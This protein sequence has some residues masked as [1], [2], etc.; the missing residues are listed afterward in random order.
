[1]LLMEWQI[2]GSQSQDDSS[3]LGE[4]YFQPNF[5][6]NTNWSYSQMKYL[7]PYTKHP[8]DDAQENYLYFTQRSSLKDHLDD[9]SVE[10]QKHYLT[11]VMS[12]ELYSERNFILLFMISS[13]FE[14]KSGTLIKII[15]NR[16][17]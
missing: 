6:W 7:I 8:S 2:P 1:M 12:I 17:K 15:R 14:K 5:Y 4:F 10:F 3:L 9:S 11:I 16:T 13:V